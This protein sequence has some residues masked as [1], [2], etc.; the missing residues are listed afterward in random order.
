[1]LHSRTIN[2]L[3]AAATFGTLLLEPFRIQL[4]RNNTQILHRRLG[5]I[6]DISESELTFS[7]RQIRKA[8]LLAMRLNPQLLTFLRTSTTGHD[9]VY[10]LLLAWK[11]TRM[12][13]RKTCK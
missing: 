10:G 2:S 7:P 8:R 12:E 6:S 1:M 11:M 4:Q 3:S 5:D 9:I 13:G